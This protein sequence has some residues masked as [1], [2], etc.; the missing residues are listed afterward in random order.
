MAVNTGIADG[1]M[2]I[3][4]VEPKEKDV[5]P[6]KDTEGVE[7]P[8]ETTLKATPEELKIDIVAYDNTV[9]TVGETGEKVTSGDCKVFPGDNPPAFITRLAKEQAVIETPGEEVADAEHDDR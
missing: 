6:P 1:N 8:D 2:L 3:I 7:M 9:K 5:Y 4:A